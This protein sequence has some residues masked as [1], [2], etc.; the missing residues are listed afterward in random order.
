MTWTLDMNMDSKTTNT[1][2]WQD[3]EE[4]SL[5]WTTSNI[6]LRTTCQFS[7]PNICNYIKL[8]KHPAQNCVCIIF[9]SSNKQKTFITANWNMLSLYKSWA[10]S[11]M[12]SASSFPIKST[13]VDWQRRD[14][15]KWKTNLF[16]CIFR[17]KKV[18][19]KRWW[20]STKCLLHYIFNDTHC[21][22]FNK[23]LLLHLQDRIQM[24]QDSEG[25]TFTFPR[26]SLK[27]KC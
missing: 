26:L 16:G 27:K 12:F 5:A 7:I 24:C 14:E 4:A 9:L 1:N 17:L 10:S 19:V 18:K 3:R 23:P 2:L 21:F 8:Q 22:L 25:I 13:L 15:Q 6:S 11:E 20:K